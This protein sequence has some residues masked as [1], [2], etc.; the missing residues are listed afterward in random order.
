MQMQ[1]RNPSATSEKS[2]SSMNSNLSNNSGN[3]YMKVTNYHGG[4]ISLK[5]KVVAESNLYEKIKLA[6]NKKR[7]G[8]TI[9]AVAK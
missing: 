3:P 8:S 2:V 1:K 7:Q 6:N 4:N 9:F 5:K